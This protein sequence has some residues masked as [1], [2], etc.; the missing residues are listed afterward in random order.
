MEYSAFIAACSPR[1]GGN[2]DAAAAAAR[3]ALHDPVCS[4]R[5]ADAGVRPCTGCGYCRSHPGECA[6]DG[7]GDGAASLYACVAKARLTIVV[8][9]VYFYHV[10]SQAKAWIDR[11]QRFWEMPPAMRP[12]AGRRLT[13]IFIGARERGEKLFSGAGLT[14]RYM[15]LA[16]GMEWIPPLCLYGYDGPSVL[17]EDRAALERIRAFVTHAWQNLG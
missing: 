17:R 13:A 2:S 15:A 6:Q 1:R 14:L 8:S 11:A 5:I 7:G 9:P 10:P 12:A 4:A 3:L 16:M